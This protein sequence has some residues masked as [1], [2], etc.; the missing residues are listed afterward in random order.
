LNKNS[1]A[2]QTSRRTS[3]DSVEIAGDET[4]FCAGDGFGGRG[5]SGDG[6]DEGGAAGMPDR[7]GHDYSA[8]GEEGGDQ[9][10]IRQSL[11]TVCLLHLG[12][13]IFL[14]TLRFEA[15]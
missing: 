6:F 1:F 7:A 5:G 13:W 15:T 9:N 12:R 10:S 3:A 14:N 2:W 4:A 8:R 11:H